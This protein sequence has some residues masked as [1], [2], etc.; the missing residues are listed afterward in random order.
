MPAPA[1][2]LDLWA[3]FRRSLIAI[4]IGNGIYFLL[5]APHLPARGQHRPFAMD[6]GLVVD[7]WVC[8]VIYG[9]L[10]L[11]RRRWKKT[12]KPQE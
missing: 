3:N 2:R 12:G 6:W 4:L 9:L 7:F 8:L 11:V 1:P 5:I 10:D